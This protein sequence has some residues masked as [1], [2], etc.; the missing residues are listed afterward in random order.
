[1][2]RPMAQEKRSKGGAGENYSCPITSRCIIVHA[3]HGQ[4]HCTHRHACCVLFLCHMIKKNIE[5]YFIIVFRYC[6]CSDLRYVYAYVC[7][8]VCVCVLHEH[9][10]YV[11][12]Y[13]PFT[14]GCD[15]WLHPRGVTVISCAQTLF[16]EPF[17]SVRHTLGGGSGALTCIQYVHGCGCVF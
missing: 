13:V 10:R 7:V 11:L 8:C 6:A 4:S 12:V 16:P 5:F 1:M 17:C 3:K 15:W 14:E 9:V 2:W